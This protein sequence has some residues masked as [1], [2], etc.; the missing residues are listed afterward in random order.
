MMRRQEEPHCDLR[1]HLSEH[2]DQDADASVYLSGG[3]GRSVRGGCVREVRE[4]KVVVVV[5]ML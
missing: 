2:D 5:V 4:E 3:E 1:Q